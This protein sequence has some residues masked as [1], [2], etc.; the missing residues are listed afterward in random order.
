[1]AAIV[2]LAL[3]LDLVGTLFGNAGFHLESNTMATGFAEDNEIREFF[4]DYLGSGVTH[5]S[6]ITGF[7]HSEVD[8][9]QV[10]D[11]WMIVGLATIGSCYIAGHNMGSTWRER[12][13]LD[14]IEI[15]S[16]PSTTNE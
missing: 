13:V 11:L 4:M 1:E 3:K 2:H 14:G 8:P 15:A 9:N 16:S 12:D 10:W 7:S 5:I 6:H